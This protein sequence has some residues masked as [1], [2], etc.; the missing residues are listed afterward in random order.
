MLQGDDVK[1]RH[2]AQ[3][4]ATGN[5]YRKLERFKYVYNEATT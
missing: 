2:E 4:G 1:M 5:A 3:L